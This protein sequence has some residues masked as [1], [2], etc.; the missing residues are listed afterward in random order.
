MR[1]SYLT[2][3]FLL[4]A[5]SIHS[6]ANSEGDI[7]RVLDSI[8]LDDYG[9]IEKVVACTDLSHSIEQAEKKDDNFYPAYFIAESSKN[10]YTKLFYDYFKRNGKHP[11]D[12]LYAIRASLLSKKIEKHIT[13]LPVEESLFLCNQ[14]SYLFLANL[15]KRAEKSKSKVNS[16][17]KRLS[18]DNSSTRHK[19][20]LDARDYKG[21]M[22]L[23]DSE[24]SQSGKKDWCFKGKGPCIVQIEGNDRFGLNKPMGWNYVD[25][26]DGEKLY[27]W[28][29]PHRIVHKGE[30]ARYIGVKRIS[31]WYQSPEVGSSGYSIG[32]N[33]SRTSCTDYG[34]GVLG[35]NI[36]CTTTG[37]NSIQIPGKESIPGGNISIRFDTVY[38]CKDNTTAN[39]DGSRIMSGGWQKVDPMQKTWW[40]VGIL[41]RQC[42]AS[43]SE[44]KNL[45][46]M[47]TKL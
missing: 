18:A 29:N 39:Y 2:V 11:F 23:N 20:C 44:L 8:N 47:Y 33:S 35:R 22:N 38:D 41:R 36:S 34:S 5:A 1:Q 7:Q 9:F 14:T 25:S 12:E 26:D 15:N 10:N 30:T 19:Q 13:S 40:V 32:G 3:I 27:Y 46:E 31:R 21:C 6:P 42:K 43:P 37:S 24:N 17:Q 28:S 16:A 45:P 4:L